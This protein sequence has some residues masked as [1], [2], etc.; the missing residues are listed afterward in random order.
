L[1]RNQCDWGLN[2]SDLIAIVTN[3]A[4]A[5]VLGPDGH[6]ME[7]RVSV[8]S[9]GALRVSSG[10]GGGGSSGSVT[11]AGV[12]GT[13]AQ[14][15]QGIS[16]GVPMPVSPNVTRGVGN[17]DANTQR[18]TLATDGPANSYLSSIDTKT[19]ATNTSLSSIDS[20]AGTTNTSLSSIDSKAGTTNTSLS[21][22]D[23][24]AGTTNTLLSNLD[25]DI[26]APADAAATTD[27]GTFSLISLI[28]RALQNWT[29]L[30]GRI[31]ALG[32]AVSTASLPVVVA[33][34]QGV[35]PVNQPGVSATGNIT[36]LNASPSTG[37]A[38][39]GSAVTLSLTGATG[40]AV[41]L[42]GTFVAT[43]T[44]QGTINGTDWFSI[45]MLPAGSGVN[46]A[47]VTT[48][49]AVGAWA[50]NANGMQ[51]VRATATAF[52]S[53][54][55]TV[56]LRA[57][58]A[59][60]V[61]YNIPGGATAQSVSVTGTPTFIGSAAEDAAATAS[62]VVVGGVVRTA[63]AP[64]T[65]V[66]GDAARDTMTAA[67]A[68]TAAI[69]APV[70]S[71]EV[72]S[73]AR[74]ATGNS[75][76]I[77]VPTG[78]GISGLLVVSAVSG[79][80]PTLDLTLE[81]SFDAGTNWLTAWSAP[82]VTGVTTVPIPQM[83]VGGLRRWVWTISGTTPSFTFA[84]NTNQLAFVPPIVRKLF[85]RT[86]NVLNGTATTPTG[87]LNVAG[88]KQIAAKIS[89]GAITTTPGTYQIQVSDDNSAWS[90]VGTP[91][92]V[93]A[94]TTLTL[95]SPAGVA[96]DWARVIVTG[97]ATGQTGNYVAIQATS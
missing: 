36:V 47:T 43:L 88:C 76:T 4:G 73:A 78:G 22:I 82:R 38:T 71:A 23:S 25:G 48:A 97:A 79:T 51:Q 63:A 28:K 40:F 67:G 1:A 50:G 3:A 41:D 64:V 17:A 19:S 10:G 16:G 60:G 30:L 42:R 74:V 85:D 56:V 18:V 52:T 55:V 72:A 26:G 81:E 54:S 61:V 89:V 39:A 94:N 83:A 86:A 96:A 92:A 45:P 90:G 49:T 84:I 69:G 93:A 13:S 33:S 75:G 2:M 14:A 58:Q 31:P 80:T 87:A 11:A 5:P 46:V 35:L 37:A 95:I 15:V 59:T 34:D 20:K 68:K 91:T 44:F 66:A 32:S 12:N 65:L 7:A 77:S 57:M 29:T 53:G 9:T 62:P 27:T 21:S 70:V 6:P 8:D 24:K